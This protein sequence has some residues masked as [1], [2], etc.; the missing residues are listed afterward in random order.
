M[1]KLPKYEYWQST[2]DLQWYFVLKGGNG[3]T[4]STSEGY[5]SKSNCLRGIGSHRYNAVI[6]RVRQ[7]S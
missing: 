3:E 4:Q 2:A 7:R 5:T 6:A 1:K